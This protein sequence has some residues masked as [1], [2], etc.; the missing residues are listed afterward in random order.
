MIL[1]SQGQPRDV[2]TQGYTRIQVRQD[3]LSIDYRY[4][5]PTYYAHGTRE[6][7][8]DQDT[9]NIHVVSSPHMR[10]YQTKCIPAIL[11]IQRQRD[12]VTASNQGSTVSLTNQKSRFSSLL[13]S[14]VTLSCFA[15]LSFVLAYFNYQNTHKVHTS[16]P[17]GRGNCTPCIKQK[18]T[19]TFSF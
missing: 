7:V 6:C 3:M 14:W 1:D 15:C 4:Y 18:D 5:I 11:Y 2:D 8:C 16:A 19:W 13:T 10:V 17:T 12:S 9:V